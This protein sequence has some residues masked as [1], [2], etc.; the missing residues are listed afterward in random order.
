[1]RELPN[2]LQVILNQLTRH[3]LGLDLIIRWYGSVITSTHA[4]DPAPY[5]ILFVGIK[6]LITSCAGF[7]PHE[8]GVPH[9]LE[10]DVVEVTPQVIFQVPVQLGLGKFPFSKLAVGI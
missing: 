4:A 9:P 10:Q 3:F 6:V 5:S 2:Q 7:V 1:M 8:V